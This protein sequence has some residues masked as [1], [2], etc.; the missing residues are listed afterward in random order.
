MTGPTDVGTVPDGPTPTPPSI[1]RPAAEPASPD[2]ATEP[3][4]VVQVVMESTGLS[5]TEAEEALGGLA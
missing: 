5:R 4:L 3:S 1:D 2:A